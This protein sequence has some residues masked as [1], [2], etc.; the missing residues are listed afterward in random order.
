MMLWVSNITGLARRSFLQQRGV[1]ATSTV[2]TSEL[3]QGGKSP[4]YPYDVRSLLKD[5]AATSRRGS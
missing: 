1:W 5:F 4:A 2:E 3:F